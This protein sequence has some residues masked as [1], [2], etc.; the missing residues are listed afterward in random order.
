[1]VQM[2]CIIIQDAVLCL[3]PVAGTGRTLS[4]SLI[5]KLPEIFQSELFL[6]YS[7]DLLQVIGQHRETSSTISSGIHVDGPVIIEAI[8]RSTSQQTVL[9]RTLA[10]MEAKH[11]KQPEQQ[12][13]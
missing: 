11:Q 3:Q 4:N 13:A 6:D 8:N 5:E 10:A 9:N 1:M 2:Q 7:K 12:D